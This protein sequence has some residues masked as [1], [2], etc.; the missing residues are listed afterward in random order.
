LNGPF[1]LEPDI[2]KP[3]HSNSGHICLVLKWSASLD[4]FINR[5][6][7]TKECSIVWNG[8]G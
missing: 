6:R 4:H 7:V 3:I 1:Q 5:K 2:W 8:L